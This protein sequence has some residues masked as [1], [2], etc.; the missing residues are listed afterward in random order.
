MLTQRKESVL[1]LCVPHDVYTAELNELYLFEMF[2]LWLTMLAK[3][4]MPT[5]SNL[6]KQ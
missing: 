6:E 1:Y 3:P 2:D 5:I 4:T